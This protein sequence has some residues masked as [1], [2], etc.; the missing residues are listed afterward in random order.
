MKLDNHTKSRGTIGIDIGPKEIAISFVKNDGNPFKYKHYN[1]ANIL[2]SRNEEKQRILSN[3]IDEIISEAKAEGFYHITIENL[4]NLNFKK[5]D[6]R[7]LNRML[8]KFPKTI[9]EDLIM[10]KCARKGIKIKKVNPAYTSIIG[11]FKYS[12]RDNLSTS[13]N[14]KSHDL[15]AALVIGRR[16]LGI[17]EKPIVSIRVFKRLISIP[18]YSLFNSPEDELRKKDWNYKSFNHLWKS[19]KTEFNSVHALTEHIYVQLQLGVQVQLTKNCDNRY[20]FPSS[21]RNDTTDILPF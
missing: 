7:N 16:G 6:N 17:I 10:S 2:D 21:I 3:I 1:I 14:S 18:I 8:S 11:L 9:F 12:N 13:H 20:R 15:S 4:D 5:S 19:L